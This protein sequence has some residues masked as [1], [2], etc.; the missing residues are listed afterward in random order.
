MDEI[1][2]V[3]QSAQSLATA[4]TAAADETPLVIG[5]PADI[6]D[7]YLE[8]AL[9]SYRRDDPPPFFVCRTDTRVDGPVYEHG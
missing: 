4:G 5:A 2:H 6:I 8:A 7:R 1:G 9:D 3:L